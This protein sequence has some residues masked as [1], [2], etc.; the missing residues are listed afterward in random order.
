MTELT[1]STKRAHRNLFER[2]RGLDK[3][4]ETE[5]SDGE[6]LARG[7]G[8]TKRASQIAAE[9]VWIAQFGG[10]LSEEDAATDD[11]WSS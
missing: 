10:N 6:H 4:Y 5:I 7:R 1:S 8:P 9:R 2:L 11:K 3:V